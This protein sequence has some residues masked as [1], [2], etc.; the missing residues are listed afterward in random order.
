MTKGQGIIAEAKKKLVDF[1]IFETPLLYKKLGWKHKEDGYYFI[2]ADILNLE[3]REIA[4]IFVNTNDA[5]GGVW[6]T[7][8][9]GGELTSDE[10]SVEKLANIADAMERAYTRK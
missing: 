6:V 1:I 9:N 5:D 2:H 3:D 10:I 4:E 7:N 8:E